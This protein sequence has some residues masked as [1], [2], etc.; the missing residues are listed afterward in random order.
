[1]KQVNLF[2][3]KLIWV[4]P[5]SEPCLS[6][7]LQHRDMN[8]FL[9][10]AIKCPLTEDAATLKSTYV[11]VRHFLTPRVRRPLRNDRMNL[12]ENNVLY[13]I[14][15]FGTFWPKEKKSGSKIHGPSGVGTPRS[16]CRWPRLRLR[17]GAR[18]LR[19]LGAAN[20]RQMY[21]QEERKRKGKRE[22]LSGMAGSNLKRTLF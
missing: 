21:E 22:R 2:D 17:Q 10:E 18:T 9:L 6:S 16:H 20:T 4:L 5:V 1:M 7:F 8:S 15:G 3:D 12:Y 14:S 11:T 19:P 13:H